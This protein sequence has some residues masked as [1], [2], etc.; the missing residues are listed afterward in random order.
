MKT[1]SIS[2]L[3]KAVLLTSVAFLA[4]Y[5]GSS[6][7]VDE[8]SQAKYEISRAESVKAEKYSAQK[9]EDAK[10]SLF[11]AHDAVSEDDMDVAKEKAEA[12]IALAKE[13]FAE[14]APLLSQDTRAEADAAIKE[15][16]AANAEEFATAEFQNAKTQYA[17]GEQKHTA[18]S[19]VEAYQSFEMSREEAI[20]AR[21]ISEAQIE[22]MRR[23]IA[24]V[25]DMIAEAE[26]YNAGSTSPAQLNNA[27]MKIADAK[28]ALEEKRLKD[29]KMSLGE[30]TNSAQNA[31]ASSQKTWAISKFQEAQSAVKDAEFRISAL[32]QSLN[33][34]EGR[35][36][37]ENSQDLQETLNNAE[38]TLT[39]AQDAVKSSE[40]ALKNSQYQESYNHSEE[41]I[42]L[43]RII[44]DQTPEVQM[45]I[46]SA[47]E[48]LGG[49]TTEPSETST[50]AEGW[51][52][53]KVRLIPER[54]DCLWRIAQYDYI[55][56][57]ARKWPKIY[58]A[59]KSKIKNPDLIYP[60]QIF[61]IPPKDSDA[62]VKP[63][64]EKEE[65]STTPAE[66]SMKEKMINRIEEETAAENKKLF[67]EVEDKAKS[68]IETLDDE[69]VFEDTENVR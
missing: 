60:G 55:Y 43:A 6:I 59:N 58:R 32:K 47:K 34:E 21:N 65:T 9:Y 33:D 61:D 19:Y 68:A 18:G 11:E 66:K 26:R 1:I 28:K 48:E 23:D 30:A 38:E 63:V 69:G 13:A 31:L 51:K 64:V 54:R 14:S 15:A 67:D 44:Q 46:S 49:K 35:K 57:D 25:D 10:R 12:A 7:P 8:M 24:K 42:R 22:G 62:T 41:A 17:N 56:A 2:S 36:A 39:A 29:A 53:Y 27:K 5:C 3:S 40:F 37:Y 16:E 52:T 45:M 20:K 50:V 4:A